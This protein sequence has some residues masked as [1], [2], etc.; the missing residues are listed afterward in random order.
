MVDSP[1]FQVVYSETLDS[2]YQVCYEQL[3][4]LIFQ[5]ESS[6]IPGYDSTSIAFRAPPLASVLPQL[7]SISNRLLPDSVDGPLNSHLKHMS[8]GALLD[9][10]CISIFDADE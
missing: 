7:K 9:S 5:P 3:R 8:S 6:P 2:C 10:L 1:V 4:K